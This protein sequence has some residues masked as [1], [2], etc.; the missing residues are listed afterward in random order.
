LPIFERNEGSEST[1]KKKAQ[2]QK[3]SELSGEK[4]NDRLN[5][6][7]RTEEVG[8]EVVRVKEGIKVTMRRRMEQGRMR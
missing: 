5:G 7:E 1:T 6:C 2:C 4:Q 8:R 3:E